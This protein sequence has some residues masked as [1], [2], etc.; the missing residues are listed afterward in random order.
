MD[1]NQL[2]LKS[3]LIADVEWNNIKKIGIIS[4]EGTQGYNDFYNQFNVPLD[5]H[6]MQISLEGVKTSRERGEAIQKLEYTDLIIII[7]GGGNTGE[8]SNSF[9]VIEIFDIIKK[10]NV[11]I[12]ISIGHEQDKGDKLLITNVSDIDFP[13]PSV[14]AKYLNKNLFNPINTYIR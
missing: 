2:M 8:I 5:I 11:P 14:C 13:A 7:R 1:Y 12:A 10:S 3:I 6:L 9:D 4:K